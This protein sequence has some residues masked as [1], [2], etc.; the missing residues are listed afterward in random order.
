MDVDV[1]L[2]LEMVPP[3]DGPPP[4]GPIDVW[5]DLRN[6]GADPVL[7]NA[8]LAVS[9]PEG[10]GEVWLAAVDRDGE[11]VPF[12]ADVNIGAPRAGDFATLQA[13]RSVGRHINLRRYLLLAAPGTYTVTARYHNASADADGVD[14]RVWTGALTAEPTS[15]VVD[16]GT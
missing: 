8:R 10:P 4:A 7:V 9:P 1:K 5:V 6:P 2:V 16:G 15:I 12:V 13:H 14:G 11:P 3:R